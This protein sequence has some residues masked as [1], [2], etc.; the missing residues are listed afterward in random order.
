MKRKVVILTLLA[1]FVAG[2]Y[3][4]ATG[5][6]KTIKV[7]ADKVG[8][9]INGQLSSAQ[10]DVL[11]YNGTIYMPIRAIGE[12]IGGDVSWNTEARE[13]RV[14]FAKSKSGRVVQVA[15]RSVY[16]YMLIEKNQIMEQLVKLIPKKDYAGMKKQVERLQALDMLAAGIGDAKLAEYATQMAFS[17][18]VIRT[19]LQSRKGEDYGTA[20]DVFLETESA[21]TDYLGDKLSAEKE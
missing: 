21:F 13:V 2:G 5:Q 14:D 15:N 7:F 16:Q 4:A 9:R 18:E 11:N 12:A 8:L 19:G 6:Y 17:A 20:V 3:A 10:P 1:T